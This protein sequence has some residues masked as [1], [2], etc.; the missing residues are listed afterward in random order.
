MKLSIVGDPYWIGSPDAE[1]TPD[2]E[3]WSNKQN[4]NRDVYI[5]FIN[6][7]G[8]TSFASTGVRKRGKMDLGSSGIYKVATITSR[9]QG[10]KFTQ[11]LQGF[12]D[13]DITIEYLITEFD[14][15]DHDKIW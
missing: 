14:K 7:L 10:G 1:T 3:K 2:G 8:H 15:L 5:A 6:Y 12:K 4:E 13:P 9:L 11:Q